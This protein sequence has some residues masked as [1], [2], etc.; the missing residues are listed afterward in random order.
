MN[1]RA[2]ILR[3]DAPVFVPGR[4]RA[5][6]RSVPM[7]RRFGF[8]LVVIGLVAAVVGGAAGCG[9]LFT[10]SGRHP[11]ATAPLVLGAPQHQ[12]FPAKA[13]RRYTLA[14][15]VVFEREGL[16][17]D[18]GA[19][20]VEAELPV[21]ASVEDARIAGV[22][23]PRVAPTVLYGQSA[24]PNV[25]APRGAGPRELLAERLV[26][27]WQAPSDGDRAWSVELG[28]D[29][30]RRARIREARVILYDDRLP[31][32]IRTALGAGAGGLIALVAGAALLLFGGRRAGRGIRRRS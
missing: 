17:V 6:M 32:S 27:P 31:A 2:R 11:I 28:P 5:R 21:V 30:V 19:F 10:F 26:G 1:E 15:Q 4:P 22:L 13:G 9:A 20:V 14:V 24:N 18:A 3:D 8:L 7:Q 23:D 16:D 25:R 29:R 12:T